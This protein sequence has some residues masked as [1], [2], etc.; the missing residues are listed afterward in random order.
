M[1]ET[2]GTAIET[3]AL[4]AP[5]PWLARV[6]VACEPETALPSLELS[7]I[8]GCAAIVARIVVRDSFQLRGEIAGIWSCSQI[9]A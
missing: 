1:R 5:N 7:Y 4:L 8:L 6:V 9:V 2:A 3:T